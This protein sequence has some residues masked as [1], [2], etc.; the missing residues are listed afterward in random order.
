MTFVTFL[1]IRIENAIFAAVPRSVLEG[2]TKRIVAQYRTHRVCDEAN[3]TR[4]TLTFIRL[5]KLCK[6]M[7]KISI[8]IK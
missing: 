2:A 1:E 6:I 3:L 4:E 5:Y 8:F 7:Y